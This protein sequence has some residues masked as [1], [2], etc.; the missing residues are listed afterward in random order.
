MIFK[1]GQVV[2]H[3]MHEHGDTS[4]YDYWR[5]FVVSVEPHPSVLD[6]RVINVRWIKPDGDPSTSVTGHAAEELILE[7]N[8][9]DYRVLKSQ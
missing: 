3:V 6:E 5:G 1:R 9:G 7:G 8:P 2:R 4:E